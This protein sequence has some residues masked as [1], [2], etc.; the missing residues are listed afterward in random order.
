L[1]SALAAIETRRA[2]EAASAAADRS[3]LQQIE[4]A[5]TEA[6]RALDIMIGQE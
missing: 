6:V 1:E 4:A 5:A 2:A 3:R